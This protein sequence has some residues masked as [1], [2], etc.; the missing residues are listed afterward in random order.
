M[1]GLSLDDIA[2]D[3]FEVWP[4]CW[5]AVRLFEAMST[6]WRVGMGGAI[7]LD[8]GVVRDVARMIGLKPKALSGAFADLR[9]MEAEALAVMA[10]SR[11]TK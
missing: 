11:G 8:Y 3:E 4:C 7:G 1:F 6:Q 10:E 9:I 2:E 5:D